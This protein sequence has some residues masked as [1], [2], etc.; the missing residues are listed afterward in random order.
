MLKGTEMKNTIKL[1]ESQLHRLIKESVKNVLN[2]M[3]DE[4]QLGNSIKGAITGFK[5]GQQQQQRNGAIQHNLSDA[6]NALQEICEYANKFTGGNNPAT[7]SWVLENLWERYKKI[8]NLFQ[9]K[10]QLYEGF[11]D[12]MNGAVNGFKTGYNAQYK[13]IKQTKN[14]NGSLAEYLTQL[15][16]AIRNLRRGGY[17]SSVCQIA[18]K[19]IREIQSNQR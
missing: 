2:E 19:M 14:L 10:K 15:E 4:G 18:E 6:V 11:F 16:N 9:A 7:D 13:D 3:T 12:K 1:T 5:A 17:A 8:S